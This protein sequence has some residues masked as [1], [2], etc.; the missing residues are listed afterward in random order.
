MELKYE[1]SLVRASREHK[2]GNVA[3]HHGRAV[4]LQK[5]KIKKTLHQ[6]GYLAIAQLMPDDG[7]KMHTVIDLL[8][9]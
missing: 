4:H 3:E 9:F 6:G 5:S 2:T 8:I 1:P 7:D